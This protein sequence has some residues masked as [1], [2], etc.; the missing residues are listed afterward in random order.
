MKQVVWAFS[1]KEVMLPFR[2]L[3]M[4]GNTFC[5]TQEF[6]D[7]FMKAKE[8]IVDLV[9]EG[10]K[11]F[12]I[13][14]VTMINMDW[15]KIGVMSALLQKHCGCFGVNLRCC[16]EGWKLCLVGSQFCLGV[17]S[18]YA[19]VGGGSGCG[20]GTAQGKTLCYGVSFFVCGG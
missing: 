5:W 8:K 11:S 7:A 12:Q 4:K 15:R 18:R 14:R 1:K 16:R 3:L 19:P 6:Q 10:V 17:E 20:M 13:N 9:K 2:E